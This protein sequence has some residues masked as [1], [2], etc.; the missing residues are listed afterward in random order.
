MNGGKMAYRKNAWIPSADFCDNGGIEGGQNISRDY[1]QSEGFKRLSHRF[2][3]AKQLQQSRHACDLEKSDSETL[4]Q[5]YHPNALVV[6]T[7]FPGIASGYAEM[8]S[9]LALR[10]LPEVSLQLS[11]AHWLDR[12]LLDLGCRWP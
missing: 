2:C 4:A 11:A 6:P 1:F 5:R 3:S 8:A 7:A 12:W 9:F 10:R